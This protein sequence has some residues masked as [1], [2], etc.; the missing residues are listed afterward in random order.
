MVRFISS[1][2]VLAVFSCPVFAG[3]PKIE[4]DKTNFDCG[5]ISEGKQDKLLASFSV[6][7]TG[8]A[9]LIISSVRPGCGCTVVKFDSLIQPGKAGIISATVNIANYHSGQISKMVTVT[10][11]AANTPTQQLTISASIQSVIDVS[12]QY[13]NLNSSNPAVP[14]TIILTSLKKDLKVSAVEFNQSQSADDKWQSK[15][16]IAI[17]FTLEATDSLRP[18]KSKVYKL[19]LTVPKANQQFTGNLVIKTNH[20]EKPEITISGIITK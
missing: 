18:D 4:F 3:T 6:K 2:A 14:H 9:P 12:E 10:S 19:N 15:V 20:P 16:P 11:N 1:L 17:P 7:N 5:S 13:V 8:D